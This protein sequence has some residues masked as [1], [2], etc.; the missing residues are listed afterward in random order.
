MSLPGRGSDDVVVRTVAGLLSSTLVRW[1]HRITAL[2]QHHV[3][4]YRADHGPKHEPGA[5]S[6]K[7]EASQASVSGMILIAILLH[8]QHDNVAAAVTFCLTGTAPLPK[9][10]P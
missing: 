6:I 4:S 1:A 2:D 5:I 10:G 8:R 9:S 3:G 7:G